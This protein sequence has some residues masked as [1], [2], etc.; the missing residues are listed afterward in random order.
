MATPRKLQALEA[1]RGDLHHVIPPRANEV[2]AA[3]TARELGLSPATVSTWLKVNGYRMVI[4]Y[5][6]QPQTAMEQAS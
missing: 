4:R 6:K 5:E 3:E 2:G 1:A